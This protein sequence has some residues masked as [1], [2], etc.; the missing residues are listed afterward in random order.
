[1]RLSDLSRLLKSKR[2]FATVGALLL[3]PAVLKATALYAQT[4]QARTRP[5]PIVPGEALHVTIEG[6]GEPV[7]LIPG[8][9]DFRPW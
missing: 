1:M 2:P 9:V 8:L 4:P 7:V 6:T 5:T 3:V